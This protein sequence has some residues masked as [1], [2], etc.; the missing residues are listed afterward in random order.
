MTGKQ[1]VRY[2][3]AALA[4]LLAAAAMGRA[5]FVGLEID[6]A[7]ALSLGYRLV[8]GDRLFATMWEPHQLSA[9]TTAPLVALFLGVTGGTTG[10]LLFVRAVMLAVKAALSVWFYRSLR[11]PL[12]RWGAYLGAL[13]LFVFTPK[14]FLGPDYVSQ[15][16]HYMLAAFLCWYGYYAP[17]PR[18]YRGLWRVAAGAV[19]ACLSFLAY[20]QS[21]AA[22]PVWFIGM[23]LL[24]RRGTE[25][26]WGPLPRGAVVFAGSCA[27][28]GG[29]FLVWVLQG[30]GFDLAAL[31]ARV[32]LVLHDPQ[33]SFTTAQRLQVLLS[34]ALGV[35]QFALRPLLGA[36][37][38]TAVSCPV[39]GRPGPARLLERLLWCFAA[40]T[41]V[42]CLVCALREGSLDYRHFYLCA[43]AAG[44]WTFWLDRRSGDNR[45]AR[46]LLFWLG[47]LPGVAAYLMILRSTLIALPTTFMYL[48]WPAV[49]GAAALCLRRKAPVRGRR[50]PLAV[51]ALL[52]VCPAVS[53]LWLVQVT[54]WKPHTLAD[55]TL[56]RIENG[57]ARGIWAD[58]KAADMQECLYEALAPFAGQGL[59]QAIGEQNGLGFLMADGTLTVA[60]ASVIS[61]TDSDPRFI[62][63]YEEMPEKLP[64]VILYDDAEVRDMADF[65]AWIEENLNITDRYTVT[66]GTASLQVLV[67][68]GWAP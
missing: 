38:L 63:Y 54:G 32:G 7:Y 18:Q 26:R 61:G 11:G 13:A 27:V 9:L 49:C 42:W 8:S 14:W 4:A 6:E 25:G 56:V 53:R 29:A 12:G 19:C 64:D 48:C 51:L 39:W 45:P 22:A 28:C 62:Q 59:L 30:M 43:T 23:L 46:A 66:H 15:Q 55:T 10:L 5:L 67:A 65:H 47:W 44:G 37:V 31:L 40:C 24:G 35:A 57:P 21:V 16:F 36:L 50:W 2:A 33:Y 20:P 3:P 34:Q 41:A 58:E 60:Q 68:D 1:A 17:G 52:L